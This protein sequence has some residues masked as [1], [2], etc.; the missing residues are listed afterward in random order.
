MA[1]LRRVG[2][3]KFRTWAGLPPLWTLVVAAS[4]FGYFALIVYCEVVRPT[5]PG[6]TAETRDGAVIVDMVKPG[7]PADLMREHHNPEPRG[8]VGWSEELGHEPHCRRHGGQESQAHD[9]CDGARHLHSR[10]AWTRLR[11]VSTR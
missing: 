5:N 2:P 6:F 7:T 1:E 3:A 11:R 10:P 8:H 4:F 9:G